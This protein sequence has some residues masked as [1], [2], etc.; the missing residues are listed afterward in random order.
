MATTK[1]DTEEENTISTNDTSEQESN[2]Q[3]LKITLQALIKMLGYVN[4]GDELKVIWTSDPEVLYL[5]LD[6]CNY[7]GEETESCYYH[8]TRRFAFHITDGWYTQLCWL[9]EEIQTN[10]ISEMG[11]CHEIDEKTWQRL[12]R[13]REEL[14]DQANT[15]EGEMQDETPAGLTVGIGHDFIRDRD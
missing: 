14:A 10:Q 1:S 15:L 4:Y 9:L 2:S 8:M 5:E 12:M 13:E 3:E 11:I 6:S 7:E